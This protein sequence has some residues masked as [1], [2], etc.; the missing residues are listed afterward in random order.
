MGAMLTQRLERTYRR[1][2][3]RLLAFIRSRVSRPEDAEDLLQEVFAQAVES[4]SATEPVDNLL[5][6]LYTVTRN[7]IVDL[8]RRRRPALSLQTREEEGPALEELIRDSGIDLDREL[9]RQ[10]VLEAL[11]DSLEELPP[12]Q[13][14][15]FLQQAV[16]GTTFRE[17]AEE[18]GVSINTLTARKRYAVRFLR[19]RLQEIKQLV[20]ELA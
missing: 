10:E 15:V 6:W 16:E 2:R 9:V 11:V 5:A 8:Y 3:P 14:E 1:E 17:I 19:H 13:R 20:D 4:L 12:E 7:R 18:T